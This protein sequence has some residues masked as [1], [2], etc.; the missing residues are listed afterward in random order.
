[1][2]AEFVI[3]GRRLPLDSIPRDVPVEVQSVIEACWQQQADMRPSFRGNGI[4][5]FLL[6]K[7]KNTHTHKH[8]HTE[9]QRNTYL[10]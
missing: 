2:I 4:I 8:T 1:M 6:A 3:S 5:L 9:A 10:I 7:Y